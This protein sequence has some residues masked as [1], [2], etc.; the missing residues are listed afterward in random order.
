MFGSRECYAMN[1]IVIYAV[2][3]WAV[4][5]VVGAPAAWSQAVPGSMV[6]IPAGEFQMG[7][8]VGGGHPDERPVHAVYVDAFY[9]DTC[10]VTNQQPMAGCAPAVHRQ[11]VT[12]QAL[13]QGSVRRGAAVTRM[14]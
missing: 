6:L 13:S 11:A 3:A 1:R 10:H 14:V 9:I 12:T 7:D 8:T 2:W 4:S 5:A